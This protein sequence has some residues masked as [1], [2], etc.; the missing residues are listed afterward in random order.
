[1]KTPAQ[2]SGT[3]KLI[4]D[5]LSARL[6]WNQAKYKLELAEARMLAAR[7]QRIE[8]EQARRS[9]QLQIKQ[10]RKELTKAQLALAK[11]EK[12]YA[13]VLHQA[14]KHKP[15]SVRRFESPRSK[16]II[17]PPLSLALIPQTT[18]RKT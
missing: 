11:M 7:R 18:M 12:L 15:R 1:M 17:P 14:Q 10:N 9:A 13:T 5:I 2:N 4:E 3:L 16:P 6:R 8:C